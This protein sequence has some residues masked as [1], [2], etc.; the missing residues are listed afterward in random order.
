MRSTDAQRVMDAANENGVLW[1]KAAV[2][3]HFGKV[4]PAI[5]SPYEFREPVI[6]T[7]KHEIDMEVRQLVRTDTP[8]GWDDKPLEAQWK[9]SYPPESTAMV[10]DRT[11]ESPLGNRSSGSHDSHERNDLPRPTMEA[12]FGAALTNAPRM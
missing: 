1:S 6:V 11:P 2:E 12:L 3:H 10:L 5:G 8:A 7:V 4:M 9:N